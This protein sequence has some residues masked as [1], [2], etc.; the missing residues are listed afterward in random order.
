[1]G[2][3]FIVPIVPIVTG[4]SETGDAGDAGDDTGTLVEQ[5][6]VSIVPRNRSRGDYGDAGDSKFTIFSDGDDAPNLTSA[7]K[8]PSAEVRLGGVSRSS[9]GPSSLAE[10]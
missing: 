6:Q 5:F 4:V 9:Q 7:Y 1:M 3:Y 2:M 10:Q 8:N